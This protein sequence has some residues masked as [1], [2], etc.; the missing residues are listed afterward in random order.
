MRSQRL[1]RWLAFAFGGWWLVV[2]ANRFRWLCCWF[3]CLR[4][5]TSG[6]TSPASCL[7]LPSAARLRC[8][9]WASLRSSS[10]TGSAS[11][12]RSGWEVLRDSNFF[13]FTLHPSYFTLRFRALRLRMPS[14][15]RGRHSGGR[16][17]PPCLRPPVLSVL[18]V[19]T[20]FPLPTGDASC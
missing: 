6:L 17:C 2:V 9:R 10:A 13:L 1:R 15:H 11:F 4:L 14:R 19:V 3:F 7:L 5:F 18:P 16:P 12:T 20:A 8:G